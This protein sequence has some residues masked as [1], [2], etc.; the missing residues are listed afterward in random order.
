MNNFE[1]PDK[2]TIDISCLKN[3]GLTADLYLILWCKY[4]NKEPINLITEHW[5]DVNDFK[6]QTLAYLQQKGFIKIT[7][8]KTVLCFELRYKAIS[9][10]EVSNVEKKWLEFLYKFP[11]KVP[12]QNGG[13]RALKISNP[14]S[15]GNSAIKKK[16]INLIK[17]NYD[18]HDHIIKVLDAELDM[19]R[20]SSSLQYMHN[21]NTWLN[22]S[23]YD[24]YSYLLDKEVDDSNK[25]SSYGQSIV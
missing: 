17:N 22:Q 2:V 12:A 4:H 20:N 14:N 7:D 23:D 6:D 15:K 16:Y 3:N 1:V 13:T 5:L 24:K 21:M 9:L 25:S 8:K 10:F 11:A 19:R 18:L